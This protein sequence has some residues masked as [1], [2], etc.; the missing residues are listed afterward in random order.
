MAPFGTLYTLKGTIHPRARKIF[1]AAALNGLELEVPADFNTSA[2]SKTPGFLAK[3]PLGQIPAFEG[4]AATAIAQHV[5]DSGPQREQL[6]GRDA[7]ARALNQQWIQFN[8]LQ[9]EA[10][11]KDLARWRMGY[12]IYSA[13]RE[14]KA[15]VDV[16]R[17][18]H[19]YEVHLGSGRSWFVNEDGEG[20]SLA[21]LVV[22]GSFFLLCRL[23]MDVEM[24]KEYPNVLRFYEGLGKVPGLAELY[25]VPL[26]EK[27][28]EPGQD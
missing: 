3:F 25:T 15:A 28:K 22:G 20:P 13:E 8:D 9:F 16:R 18:L 11:V 10:A 4:K 23:Y 5:A 14:A 7:A 12:E 24:R 1:A 6:L 19:H 21:D 27:R 26:L 2:A 17:W